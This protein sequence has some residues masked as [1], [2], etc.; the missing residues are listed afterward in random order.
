MFPIHREA[1][2]VEL[3][4]RDPE[5]E[6]LI[7]C[8]LI[9]VN[10]A[11]SIETESGYPTTTIQANIEMDDVQGLIAKIMTNHS[12]LLEGIGKHKY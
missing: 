2:T 10:L 5:V 11:R 4:T 8:F 6:D 12:K 7:D 9:K 1:N 3:G